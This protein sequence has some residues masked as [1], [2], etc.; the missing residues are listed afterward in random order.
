MGYNRLCGEHEHTC[1]E[2]GKASK[3]TDGGNNAR[4]LIIGVSEEG[5][6]VIRARL[7]S[8]DGESQSR[9]RNEGKESD[10]GKR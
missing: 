3:Q 8:G 7:W 4:N 1:E 6:C 5:L 2:E 10:F 9:K